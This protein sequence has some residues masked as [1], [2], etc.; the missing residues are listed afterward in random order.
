MILAP[1]T[2]YRTKEMW[3]FLYPDAY[4]PRTTLTMSNRAALEAAAYWTKRLGIRI[5]KPGTC[6]VVLEETQST[7]LRV[8]ATDGQ[9]GWLEVDAWNLSDIEEL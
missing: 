8:L 7:C 3:W 1:G 2:L 5:L 9:S 6:F 4:Q